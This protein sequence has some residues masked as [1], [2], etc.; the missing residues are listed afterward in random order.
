[1]REREREKERKKERSFRNTHH[2]YS[3]SIQFTNI[4]HRP[5]R[6]LFPDNYAAGGEKQMPQVRLN[7]PYINLILL[8]LLLIIFDYYFCMSEKITE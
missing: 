3:T 2:T 4:T 1:M 7:T 5:Y 6:L 8:L